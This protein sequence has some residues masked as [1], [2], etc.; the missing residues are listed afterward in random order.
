MAKR[1]DKKEGGTKLKRTELKRKAPLRAKTPLRARTKLQPKWAPKQSKSRKCRSKKK[2]T[3]KTSSILHT[4]DG[5]CYLC[6][7]LH[8]S[9]ILHNY[10]EEHHIF[11]GTAKRMLSEKYGLKV[12]L[13]SAHHRGDKNGN[14]EA[15]HHNKSINQLLRAAGQRA[16]EETNTRR[17]FQQL[18]EENHIQGGL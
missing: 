17:E 1:R 5:T 8:D 13:C 9:F 14:K 4:K 16:F 15:V 10:T 7:L 11:F 18:F 3:K 2:R 6:M 12:Y